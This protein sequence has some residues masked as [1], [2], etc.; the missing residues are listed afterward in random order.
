M[1]LKFKYKKQIHW[2]IKISLLILVCCLLFNQFNKYNLFN[3]S[4]PT[5]SHPKWL[6]ASLLLVAVNIGWELL[7]WKVVLKTAYVKIQTEIKVK[8]FFAGYL[9]GFLTPNFIGNFIGRMY[10]FERKDR[11]SIIIFT[12][13]SNAAQFIAS[14]LFGIIGIY[15]LG[16][17]EFTSFSPISWLYVG[18]LLIGL[19]VLAY[20]TIEHLQILKRFRQYRRILIYL[21]GN[22]SFRWKLLFISCIRHFTFTLQFFFI[23]KSMGLNIT[24]DWFGYIWQIYFWSTIIPSLWLGKIGIRESFALL[25]LTPLCNEPMIIIFTSL[26]L[27]VINQILPALIGIP[28]LKLKR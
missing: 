25:I 3:K 11:P 15:W 26:S 28:F 27:F 1:R 7:K 17:P 20:F 14:M 10:Y 9:T 5:I 6:I 13:F 12:L 16:F 19:I 23:L 18:L 21:Q 2:L 8:S 22:L 24:I 4:I